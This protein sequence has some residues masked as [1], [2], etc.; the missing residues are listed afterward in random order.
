MRNISV[1]GLPARAVES[2]AHG[3]REH[4]SPAK[5]GACAVSPAKQGRGGVRTVVSTS[6]STSG[7]ARGRA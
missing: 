1:L 3:A 4:G 6:E 5:A 7:P 2:A